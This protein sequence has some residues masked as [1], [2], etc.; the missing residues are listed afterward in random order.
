MQT[1]LVLPCAGISKLAGSA[2]RPGGAIMELCGL[3]GAGK[4]QLCLQICASA[5]IPDSRSTGAGDYS[6]VLF[7]DTEGSFVAERYAQVCRA[8][9]IEGRR[10]MS[11]TWQGGAESSVDVAVALDQVLRGMH[12]C[13]PYDAT[14]LYATIKRLG[15]TLKERPRI[16]A[17]VVDSLAFFFRHEFMDDLHKRA[18][19]LIDIATELRQLGST[20]GLVVVVTNHM[21]HKFDKG[22][23]ESTGLVPALG[24]T[25][26]HQ[27]S[28]Q[29]RLERVHVPGVAG[30]HIGKAV[31]SKSVDQAVGRSVYYR[32]ASQGICDVDAAV[33]EGACRPL[34]Q[35]ASPLPS[36]C[37]GYPV[38]TPLRAT[39]SLVERRG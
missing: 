28:T 6:E 24:E 20:Y 17:V 36:D 10:R 25:W 21:T 13:R 39:S 35:V 22:S 38:A 11:G 23:A 9:L 18:R 27:P 34:T 1:P 8:L 31:L 30:G 3:P 33:A 19:L 37:K 29:I 16:R 32:I 5:Q 14:E 15:H 26:A 4:T 2:L 12:V 7:I